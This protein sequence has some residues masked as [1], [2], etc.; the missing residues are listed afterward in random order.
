VTAP[1][2]R[3]RARLWQGAALAL[4]AALT[5]TLT[6]HTTSA[7][8]T[9]QTTDGGN[10]ATASSNF[11]ASSGGTTLIAS[12]DTT[13]YQTNPTTTYGANVDI[14][15]GSS[16]GANG[17]VLL[18]FSLPALA[19]HCDVTAAALR[20]Y[21]HT[22][23]AGRTI[24]VYRVDPGGTWSEGTTNWNNFPATTGTAVGSASLGSAGWQQWTVTSMVTALYAGTN[25]GFLVRDRTEGGAGIWQLWAA[26]ENGTV[27]NRPQLVLTW[28]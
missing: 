21:A 27:A 5:G 19:A 13:G 3:R 8:F 23:V 10:Q 7:A 4:A 11:C 12:A 14:G 15:V 22:P 17:R 2:S 24:D 28:G 6:Q 18:R 9:A 1:R 16:A 25:S 20:L 26:R